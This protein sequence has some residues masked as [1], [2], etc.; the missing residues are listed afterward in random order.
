MKKWISTAQSLLLVW[1]TTRKT[2]P[3]TGHDSGEFGNSNIVSGLSKVLRCSKN[4]HLLYD[5]R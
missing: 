5:L 2:V 3:T 1:S 4:Q